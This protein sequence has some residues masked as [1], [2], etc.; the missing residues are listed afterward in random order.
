MFFC[1][2]RLMTRI[3]KLIKGVGIAVSWLSLTLVIV[4][5]VDVFLRYVFRITSAASFELEWHL[6]G[7]LF[8]L[9]ASY[10]LQQ[11][12]HVR[13]D[14]FYQRFSE[15]GKAWVNLVGTLLLLIPF[16]LVILLESLSFV[17]NSYRIKEVS[18]DPGGLPA[19]FIIKSM[20]PIGLSLL[21]LQGVSLILKS[22]RMIK[23]T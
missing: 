15:K 12:K 5:V 14:V 19:R 11:D 22:I 9:G 13:V 1:Y 20:I 18:P 10:T 16:C 2:F 3:D 8:F 4:I 23:K 21:I 6:F 7:T 17:E